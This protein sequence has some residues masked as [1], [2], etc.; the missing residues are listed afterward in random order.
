MSE[1][2]RSVI[3]LVGGLVLLLWGAHWFVEGAKYTAF[4]LKI[5]KYAFGATVV[6]IGT[7][8][9]EIL[10]SSY[11]A[12]KGKVSISVSTILGSNILNI[13]FIIGLIAL[14][15]EIKKISKTFEDHFKAKGAEGVKGSVYNPATDIPPLIA[16]VI[17]FFLVSIDGKIIFFEG[18]LM[19]FMGVLFVTQMISHGKTT[20]L[21]SLEEE[22]IET[23]KLSKSFKNI[24]FYP[25]TWGLFGAIFIGLILGAVFL[26]VGTRVAVNNAVKLAK[27]LKLSEWFIGAT[28][29]AFGTS[30]PEF[31]TSLIAKWKGEEEMLI[32]NIIGSLVINI[33]FAIG[34]AAFFR[35][36]IV[37]PEVLYFDLLSYALILVFFIVCLMDLWISRVSG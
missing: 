9:P 16:S 21:K 34:I 30:A 24:V 4:K 20:F 12:F 8:L 14:L 31:V 32:G 27:L 26:Y 25:E 5:P 19:V 35:P 33:F 18:L 3:F 7:S 36:I 23:K 13:A 22:D 11:A 2:L 6:A 10:V 28:I 15:F 17:I 37:S 1:I 29:M